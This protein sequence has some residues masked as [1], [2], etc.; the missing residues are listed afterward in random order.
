MVLN[1]QE[2]LDAVDRKGERAVDYLLAT[3]GTPVRVYQLVDQAARRGLTTHGI[4]SDRPKLTDKGRAYLEASRRR[5]EWEDAR[6]G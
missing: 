2:Y 1:L 6:H 3:T 5:A 4:F